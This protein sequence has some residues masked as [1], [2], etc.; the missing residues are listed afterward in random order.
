[1]SE[2]PKI[3]PTAEFV[4]QLADAAE[5]LNSE[6][7]A[8]PTAIEI[9]V[10]QYPDKAQV[11]QDHVEIVR[12]RM[13]LVRKAL[14]NRGHTVVPVA[15]PYY[16]IRTNDPAGIGEEQISQ[17][18]AIGRGKRG[19]GILF[20]TEDDPLSKRIMVHHEGWVHGTGSAKVTAT[21]AR[22]GAA[23]EHGV[24]SRSEALAVVGDPDVFPTLALTADDEGEVVDDNE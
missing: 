17:C 9:A 3:T 12:R 1:M 19:I 16:Q 5:V 10:E 6:G 21:V 4:E 11:P 18:V 13:P 23:V 8:A 14:R 24:I 22:V 7:K 15:G 20:A 2:I